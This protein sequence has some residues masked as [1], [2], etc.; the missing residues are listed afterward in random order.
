MFRHPI[1]VGGG[2]PFLPPLTEDVPLELIETRTFG[3]RVIY[4]R[5]GRIRGTCTD[6]SN[7]S[8]T[9]SAACAASGSSTS[10]LLPL[11]TRLLIVKR[12]LLLRA[13][14]RTAVAAL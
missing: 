1:I 6:T 7:G 5:Y 12:R 14:T 4:E 13:A 8:L 9:R 3:S 11:H 10:H 2:T